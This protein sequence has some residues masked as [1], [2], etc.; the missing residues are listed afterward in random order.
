[1]FDKMRRLLHHKNDIGP[2]IPPRPD[3]PGA[4]N[5]PSPE[6]QDF[7]SRIHRERGEAFRE[8]RNRRQMNCLEDLRTMNFYYDKVKEDELQD[9]MNPHI[10]ATGRYILRKSN[11]NPDAFTISVVHTKSHIYHFKVLPQSNMYEVTK[12]LRFRTIHEILEY[13]KN[14]NIPGSKIQNLKLTYPISKRTKPRSVGDRPLNMTPP[15]IPRR[16]SDP[17]LIRIRDRLPTPPPTDQEEHKY[18]VVDSTEEDKLEMILQLCKEQDLFQ[19]QMRKRCLCGLYY[20]ESILIHDWMMH[21]M[22]NGNG[23]IF[24]VNERTKDTFWKLPDEIQTD[25]KNYYPNRYKNFLRLQDENQ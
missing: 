9:I 17:D 11:S 23:K 4:P 5:P 12:D 21:R 6:R 22:I 18:T 20:D 3:I 2:P 13:F 19:Q 14:N 24:F 25:L 16:A 1:M 10:Y 8:F 7:A 15:V